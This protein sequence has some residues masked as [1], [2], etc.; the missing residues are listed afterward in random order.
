MKRASYAKEFQLCF[1]D[2]VP[3]KGEN[4]IGV[5]EFGVAST[6]ELN[7]VTLDATLQMQVQSA[8]AAFG[9]YWKTEGKTARPIKT[10]TSPWYA[11][12][13]RAQ[14]KQYTFVDITQQTTVDLTDDTP[15]A[16]AIR[17]RSK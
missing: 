3:V 12:R 10:F 2:F 1:A 4:E 5:L 16:K 17:T 14:G 9:V 6:A 11:E 13:L 7:P 8:T 15:I